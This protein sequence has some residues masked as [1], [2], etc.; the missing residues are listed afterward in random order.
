MQEILDVE[1]FAHVRHAGT[2]DPGID[3]ERRV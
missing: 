3:S 1:D 2:T